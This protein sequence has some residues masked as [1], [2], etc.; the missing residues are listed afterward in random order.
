MAGE[1]LLPV[2]AEVRN[3][4]AIAAGDE[5]DV[6]IALDTAPREVVVPD[7]L[8]AALGEVD[9]ARAFFDAMSEGNRRRVVE[10]VTSAKTAA[11]RERRVAKEVE[12]MAAGRAR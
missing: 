4:A 3:A 11:T 10:H 6:E 2:S 5:I 9:G 1:Y 8:A 12:A 7:D